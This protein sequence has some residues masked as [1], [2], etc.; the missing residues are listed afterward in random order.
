MTLKKFVLIPVI[1]GVLACLIQALDQLLYSS[2][3]PEGNVGFRLISFQSW[4]VY[5]LAGCTVRGGIKA[6]IAYAIGIA[7]S[8]VI[9]VIGGAL[10]PALGFFAVPVAVGVIAFC[11]IFCE[12]NE[13]LSLVPALFIGAG[14]FFAF[15]N[16]V[17]NATFC[18]AALTEMIYCTI[19]LLFGYITICLR[20][21]YEKKVNAEKE[22][23]K[24]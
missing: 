17:P 7:A 2:V 9:M 5:F 21:A 8:I 19:G 16:Y 4:A 6:F 3:P 18:T 22:E 14:A 11:A 12:R 20:T 24:E 10:T 23:G 13:W 1:I 15:M